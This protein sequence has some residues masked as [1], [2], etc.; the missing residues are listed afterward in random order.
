[1]SRLALIRDSFR[2]TFTSPRLW[3][4]H[5]FANAMLFALVSAW[6]LIP[7]ANTLYLILNAALGVLL[8]IAVLILHAGTLN[9]FADRQSDADSSLGGSLRRAARHLAAVAVCLIVFYGLWLLVDKCESYSD[10]LPA[11]IRSTLPVALRRHLTLPV[12]DR[13]FAAILFAAR[14]I[15]APALVLPLL[16]QS[17]NQGFRGF[18]FAGISAWGR[19]IASIAY[20]FLLAVAAIAGVVAAGK[21]MDLTPDF[22]SSTFHAELLSFAARLLFAY[23]LAICAWL[24]VC[25]VVARRAN[26]VRSA[27]LPRNSAA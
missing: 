11:Y 21:V 12:L 23:L 5:F 10:T 14:W 20:W 9:Y 27:G 8:L 4:L 24:L 18:T 17:A 16:L 25:S 1:M 6:L 3:L 26:A 13:L 15:F 19:S 7:V 22:K 2:D